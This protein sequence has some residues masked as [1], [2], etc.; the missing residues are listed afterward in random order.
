MTIREYNTSVKTVEE[1]DDRQ[2]APES[3]FK[4]DGRQIDCYGPTSDQA[5]VIL[6]TAQGSSNNAMVGLQLMNLVFQHI[7]KSDEDANWIRQRILDREDNFTMDTFVN[8]VLDLTEEWFATPTE[9][10]P[11][12]SPRPSSTGKKSTAKRHKPA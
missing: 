9:Q 6:M 4:V 5:A 2:F 11:E 1:R 3:S 8:I 7:I 12:S 10:S